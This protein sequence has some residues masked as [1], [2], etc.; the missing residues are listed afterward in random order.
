MTTPA[1]RPANILLILELYAG[2][3]YELSR[4]WEVLV[5]INAPRLYKIPPKCALLTF[6]L[7]S[8]DRGPK[9]T[10]KTRTKTEKKSDLAATH[11]APPHEV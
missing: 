6:S 2:L 1:A 10:R 4:R 5:E 11:I 9:K 7:R 3:S 8:T